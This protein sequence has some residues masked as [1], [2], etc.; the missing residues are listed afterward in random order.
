MLKKHKKDIDK[1]AS[2]KYDVL[3]KHKIIENK[4]KKSTKSSCYPTA[5]MT[6][7]GLTAPP[8]KVSKQI[9]D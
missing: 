7:R 5:N 1:V 4:V 9:L 6:G 3:Q 8:G 2:S